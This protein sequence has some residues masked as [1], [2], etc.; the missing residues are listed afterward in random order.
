MSKTCQSL[1]MRTASYLMLCA[2]FAGDCWKKQ[3]NYIIA[4][5]SM[6]RSTPQRQI[7]RRHLR[8]KRRSFTLINIPSLLRKK[9]TIRKENFNRWEFGTVIDINKIHKY[10]ITGFRSMRRTYWKEQEK[11]KGQWMSEFTYDCQRD[12]ETH[13]K[14]Y[15]YNSFTFEVLFPIYYFSK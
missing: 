4:R 3:K 11:K 2:L 7:S 10:I 5:Y 13:A 15:L 8:E 9:K 14:H 6:S 1:L 12:W